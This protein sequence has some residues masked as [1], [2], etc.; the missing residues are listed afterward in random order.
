M[1]VTKIRDNT[2]GPC[3]RRQELK[4]NVDYATLETDETGDIQ[5]QTQKCAGTVMSVRAVVDFILSS[6]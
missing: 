3:D 2:I 4:M 5:L 1:H 6:R